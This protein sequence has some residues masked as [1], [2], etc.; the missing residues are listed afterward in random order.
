[1]EA[2]RDTVNLGVAGVKWLSQ[3]TAQSTASSA[4]IF[5]GAQ[6]NTSVANNTL[7]E[8]CTSKFPPDS[9]DAPAGCSIP[10]TCNVEGAPAKIVETGGSVSRS[11]QD[12]LNLASQKLLQ[13]GEPPLLPAITSGG[14]VPDV[15]QP[16]EWM[17][18]YGTN[19]ASGTA[20]WAG[21]FPTSLG[22]T[23]VTINGKSAYL[24]FVSY[25]Q[26]NLQVPDDTAAG[27]V[28]VVVTTAFGK[29]T[30]T[31]KLAQFGPSFFLLDSRH[32]AAII[33]RSDG[34]GAY[35]GGSYDILGPTGTSLGYQTVAAKAG[36]V[37]ELFGAGFGPTDPAVPAG[38]AF[39]GSAPTTS[40]V[41]LRI[42]NVS[43]TPA[44][45]GLS[46]PGVYQLNLTVPAGLGAGDM[47]LQASVGGAQTPSGV[48][49][50]LQ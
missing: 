28:P 48:V 19:L 6:F 38:Q 47:S 27:A 50:S 41:T 45:A 35:G 12:L 3:S 8:G 4:Q 5:G 22:G 40:P 31:V 1:M 14:V 2:S 44:F 13:I 32:V 10:S 20:T 21:D 39:S 18:F 16:G 33:L 29:A 15:V 26:I 17:S 25:G 46:G 34:S 24:S 30:S 7:T 42:N 49:I 37:I 43:L 36:D 11:A 9:S 23:S